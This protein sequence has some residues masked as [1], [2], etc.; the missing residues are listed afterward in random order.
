MNARDVLYWGHDFV[1]RNLNG[2]ADEHWT[3]PNVCGWWSVRE[4]IA[5]LASHELLFVDILQ[6]FLGDE[7]TPTLDK[8]KRSHPRFN[9]DEVA[10]R[11]GKTPADVLAE[12]KA[13]HARSLELIVQIP[14][15][16]R[17]QAGTLPWYGEAYD[18]EDYIAYGMY[19]HKREHMAQ[20]NVFK[21]VLKGVT[22]DVSGFRGAPS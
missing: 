8:F 13:H 20:V 14:V 16:V 7:P 12:Y 10:L 17:R 2:L 19:G 6:T 5:H 15:E 11:E 22:P 18:L 9:D 4:I 21:D 1:L 3:S